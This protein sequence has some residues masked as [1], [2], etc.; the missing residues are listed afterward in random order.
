MVKLNRNNSISRKEWLKNSGAIVSG[1]LLNN[2]FFSFSGLSKPPKTILLVSGWQD[3]NI[4]DIAHTPGL[5]NVLETFLPESRIILWKRSYSAEVEEIL[6]RNFPKVRIIHGN[7]NPDSSVD[8]DDV[9][10][11]FA[12]A[13][14][15]IHGSGQSVVGK[16]NPEIWESYPRLKGEIQ[17][18]PFH[19]YEN[20]TK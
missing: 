10:G 8:S 5:L 12:E 17:K 19:I 9:K 1:I 6:T 15:M 18:F 4:G 14:L 2:L 16:K 7:V 3:I 11:A 20:P 13:D